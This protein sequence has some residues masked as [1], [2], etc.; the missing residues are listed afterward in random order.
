MLD[1]FT[2]SLKPK[3][4]IKHLFD[5]CQVQT[6]GYMYWEPG[7]KVVYE[8]STEDDLNEKVID[9]FKAVAKEHERDMEV[10]EFHIE[11]YL[12]EEP[13]E[14]DFEYRFQRYNWY[15][16]YS[17]YMNYNIKKIGYGKYL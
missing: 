15:T 10:F 3:I 14:D 1:E 8:I 5:V 13:Y 6:A 12:E 7:M 2:G 17:D 4:Y 11:D 9:E 16:F